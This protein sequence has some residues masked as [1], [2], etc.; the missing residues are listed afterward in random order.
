MK[1]EVKKLREG[2]KQDKIY[3]KLKAAEK[4]RNFRH[5]QVAQIK[6]HNKN[7]GE[8]TGLYEGDE[9]TTHRTQGKEGA[10]VQGHRLDTNEEPAEL[11]G[12]ADRRQEEIRR[13][14]LHNLG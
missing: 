12:G 8:V 13:D 9:H 6:A 11:T 10:Q 5:A 3:Q 2:A 14:A 7:N 1:M 4:D